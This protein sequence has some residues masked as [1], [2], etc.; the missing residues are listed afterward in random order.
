[1]IRGERRKQIMENC[2]ED[3]E[4]ELK[5]FIDELESAVGDIVSELSIKEI[6]DIERIADGFN[7]ADKLADSLY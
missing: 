1:M 5:A 4:D 3:F 6:T 7:L 2:P